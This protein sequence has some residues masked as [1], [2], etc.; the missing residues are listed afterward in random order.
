MRNVQRVWPRL[1]IHG[2]YQHGASWGVREE[3]D[4]MLRADK[5]IHRSRGR[6]RRMSPN[7]L[8]K[9]GCQDCRGLQSV[10]LTGS[11]RGRVM[12][13]RFSPILSKSGWFEDHPS[14]L[15]NARGGRMSSP[16]K[17]ATTFYFTCY[18]AS[19]APVVMAITRVHTH[20]ENDFKSS[21][22]GRNCV[23]YVFWCVIFNRFEA[24]VLFLTRHVSLWANLFNPTSVSTFLWF[25]KSVLSNGDRA[26]R[27][28]HLCRNCGARA[29]LVLS[30][31]P[32]LPPMLDIYTAPFP[33][34]CTYADIHS[35]HFPALNHQNL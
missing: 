9:E 18:C 35:W 16:M 30:D 7:N 32:L 3:R 24:V 26:A 5:N 4:I 33:Q 10:A 27:I 11:E 6:Q 1:I 8:Q 29:S 23:W 21:S 12:V 31:G 34:E 15:M 20:T 2:D 25:V 19:S 17:N 13:M 22:L 14:V 28:L